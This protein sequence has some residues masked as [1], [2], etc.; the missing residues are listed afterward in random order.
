[1]RAVEVELSVPD[2]RSIRMLINVTPIRPG[3]GE[4]ESVVVTK[5]DLASLK[6]LE[7]L[8]AEFLA[9][10]SHELRVPLTSIKGSTAALLSGARTL[11]AAKARQFVRIIDGQAEQM[12]ALIGDLLDAG[13]IDRGTL[14]VTPEPVEVAVLVDRARTAFLSAGPGT[15]TR[16]TFILPAAAEDRAAAASAG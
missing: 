12:G 9:M 11:D 3:D 7:R 4:V 8:R 16:I 13:R 1:M 10:V 15:G 14:W 2:G 6:A 5:Q